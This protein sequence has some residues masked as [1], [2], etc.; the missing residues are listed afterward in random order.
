MASTKISLLFLTIFAFCAVLGPPFEAHASR[1][2]KTADAEQIYSKLLASLKPRTQSAFTPIPHLLVRT[3]SHIK[4]PTGSAR[5]LFSRAKG[6]Y[7]PITNTLTVHNPSTMSAAEIR[8]TLAHELGHALALRQLSPAEL[9]RWVSTQL[10][11]WSA[12][13]SVPCNTL[14]SHLDPA[15]FRPHPLRD[16]PSIVLQKNQAIPNRYA[17]SNAHE[18]FAESFAHWILNSEL[19]PDLTTKKRPDPHWINLFKKIAQRRAPAQR[20][21][22]LRAHHQRAK[23]DTIISTRRSN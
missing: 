18:F 11:Q 8:H 5:P 6:A 17:L 19:S 9:C 3:H 21:S 20:R 12:L 16:A 23:G 2:S 14:G 10:S 4:S 13:E 15:L 7:D 1:L 22:K